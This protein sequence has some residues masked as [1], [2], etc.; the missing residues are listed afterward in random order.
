MKIFF[1]SHFANL[2]EFAKQ[3]QKTFFLTVLCIQCS[4]Y[5]QKN[6]SV[7]H[8]LSSYYGITHSKNLSYLSTY[9][10]VPVRNTKENCIPTTYHYAHKSSACR[11][12]NNVTFWYEKIHTILDV[13]KFCRQLSKKMHRL[14]HW[15]RHHSIQLHLL[16][17]IRCPVNC[18]EIINRRIPIIP[19]NH[20]LY[21]TRTI[22]LIV[23]PI[24]ARKMSRR[25]DYRPSPKINQTKRAFVKCAKTTLNPVNF[26]IK[27]WH[28]NWAHAS[29]ATLTVTMVVQRST[30][31]CTISEKYEQFAIHFHRWALTRNC[32]KFSTATILLDCSWWQKT[33]AS[34]RR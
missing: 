27:M 19:S 13:N 21:H 1:K 14:H 30:I 16:N 12:A 33:I 31:L 17:A 26:A 4:L 8:R 11:K 18:V 6:Y 32:W 24:M 25:H 7:V 2:T 29:A 20:T 34:K 23:S 9:R 28:E 15:I 3:L 5:S 22:A 10:S